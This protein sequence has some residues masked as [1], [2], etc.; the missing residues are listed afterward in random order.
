M[1]EK[2]KELALDGCILVFAVG[3]LLFVNPTGSPIFEG[4]G[5]LSWRSLPLL[6]SG[7][8]LGLAVFSIGIT[9]VAGREAPKTTTPATDGQMD[10]PQSESEML[11]NLRRLGVAVALILYSQ[12]LVYMGFA[13]STPVF[14][15]ALLFLF[16]RRNLLE[17]LAVSLI[18]GALLWLLFA[19]LLRMPL[20]GSLWDPLT[21][22]LM[23][24]LR[25][26]GG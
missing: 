24:T 23:H 21:P 15:F 5:G 17:N 6:Y 3:G 2:T 12:A 9:L 25:A 8:L 20:R 22:I 11:H 14:L 1:N 16:G 18:G 26:I 10:E 19:Y 4:P 13:L 7:L